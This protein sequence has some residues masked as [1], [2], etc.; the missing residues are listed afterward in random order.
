M[1]KSILEN[2]IADNLAKID[3]LLANLQKTAAR[4]AA[5]TAAETAAY[6]A[7]RI[8]D[9]WSGF[10]PDRGRH[11][12]HRDKMAAMLEDEAREASSRPGLGKAAG[13]EPSESPSLTMLGVIRGDDGDNDL[14]S[15]AATTAATIYGGMGWDVLRGGTAGDQLFGEDDNDVLI[16]WRGSDTLDGGDGY[17]TVSYETETGGR[18][19]IV[20]LGDSDWTYGSVLYHSMTG[21]DTWGDRDTYLQ[22]ESLLGSAYGDVI[23]AKATAASLMLYGGAGNDTLIGGNSDDINVDDDDYLIGGAGDD[24]FIDGI[25][26]YEGTQGVSVDLGTGQATGQGNDTFLTT[27]DG[28]FSPILHVIGSE[29]NDVLKAGNWSVTLE[30]GGGNDI[31]YGSNGFDRL[32]VGYSGDTTGKDTVYGSGGS[33]IILGNF[34]TTLSYETFAGSIRANLGSSIVDKQAIGG[35]VPGGSD[36]AQGIMS[37]RGTAYGDII[38]GSTF[39]NH[40]AGLG[41]NDTIN[42]D[43]GNDTLDGGDGDDQL[44]GLYDNDSLVGG[45]GNDT[46]DGGTGN[47]TMVGGGGDDVMVG[48]LGNDVFYIDDLGDLVSELNGTSGGAD[49]AYISVKNFDGRKLGNIENIVLV[50]GGSVSGQN[51]AP[52]IEGAPVAVSISAVDTGL[53]TPFSGITIV[54]DSPTVTVKV[55]MMTP[56]SGSFLNTGTGSYDAATGIFTFSGDIATVQARLNALQFDPR[57]RDNAQ[58]GSIESTQFK[59]EVFDGLGLAAAPNTNISVSAA[60]ANR[61]PGLGVPFETYTVSDADDANLVAPFAHVTFSEPNA[62]DV[63]T[64]TITLD[65]AAKGVLV[66]TSGGSYDAATG[67]FTVSGNLQSV[68]AAVHALR[69]DATN[70]DGAVNG[71]IET[72]TF[73]IKIRDAGGLSP[74]AISNIKVDSVHVIGEVNHAPTAPALSGGRIAE[75]ALAGAT[76]GLLSASDEDGHAVSFTFAQARAD[77]NG[78]ISANGAFEIAGGII[79]VRDASLIQVSKDTTATYEIVASDGHGGVTPGNVAITITNVNKAPTQLSLSNAVVAEHSAAGTVIGTLSGQDP[80]GDS[81]NYMMIENAGGRV[82]LVNGAL[83]IKDSAKAD[84]EQQSSFS[85]IVAAT[86]GQSVLAKSFVISLTDVR[87]ELVTGNAGADMIRGGTGND[88]FSGGAGNDTLAGGGGQDVLTGG[89]GADVFLFD[90]RVE[91]INRDIIQDF[92][93]EQGDR[94]QLSRSVFKAFGAADVG[95]L[96]AS[97]FAGGYA[98]T[99]ANDRILYD[100]GTGRLYYDVD[101]NGTAGYDAAPMLIATLAT[102]PVLTNASFYIV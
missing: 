60:A 51:V 10:H 83:R 98:P 65:Q 9:Q 7:A 22:I 57:D 59:I 42:G 99:D 102:K 89:T 24:T 91:L 67:I 64:V 73:A 23:N 16:G 8:D 43:A 92:S 19:A 27:Y 14:G 49:T 87:N 28:K 82:E 69:F 95:M 50:N 88:T 66:P 45:L 35:G 32:Y 56:G 4:T 61:A 33:D 71:S 75:T 72:T 2:E 29:G 37:L 101:G 5:E 41:G 31:L 96:N 79:K 90:G 12:R 93:V 39:A 94:I 53:A 15:H 48:G 80:D 6:T 3:D 40:L 46:L 47:D 1:T 30:G 17:D 36:Q 86:D 84:F 21:A 26:M 13:G 44:Y 81:L 20:N 52:V 55:T 70:R 58:V 97:A 62:N 68:T 74:S 77:S 63:V 78:L 100:Q 18:G 85:V 11:D 76:V 38:N 54:D 34:K 25:V